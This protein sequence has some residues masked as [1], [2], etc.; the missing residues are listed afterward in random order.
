MHINPKALLCSS[1]QNFPQTGH[2]SLLSARSVLRGFTRRDVA[3]IRSWV[4][5]NPVPNA[6]SAARSLKTRG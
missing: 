4:S 3:A 5:G 1:Y 2:P 6:L